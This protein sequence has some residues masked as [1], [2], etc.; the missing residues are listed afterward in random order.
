MSFAR[1]ARR[2]DPVVPASRL[3]SLLRQHTGERPLTS[4]GEVERR[5]SHPGRSQQRFL[6]LNTYLMDVL[7][8]DGEKPAVDVRDGET[9]TYTAENYDLVCLNE[10]WHREERHDLLGRWPNSAHIRHKSG[11]RGTNLRTM[12]ASAGLVTISRDFEIVA[13]HF[14]EY[15]ADSG[16]DRLAGKGCLLT[17]LTVPGAA[18]AV[19]SSLNLYNTHFQ[20]GGS[21]R[22][23]QVME[24][25]RFIARTR[26][27]VRGDLGRPGRRGLNGIVLAGDFNIDRH[28]DAQ[29]DVDRLYEEFR[30]YPAYLRDAMRHDV[31]EDGSFG[32]RT[33]R[34]SEYQFLRDIMR[35]L[36]LRDLWVWRN[37]SPGH[38]SDVHLR[39]IGEIICRPDPSNP[40]LCDDAYD[41][42]S[43]G[44]DPQ[45]TAIDYIF[46]SQTT[47]AMSFSMDFTRPRRPR[48]ARNPRAPDYLD[49]AWLSDHLG[50]STDIL[51]S[52]RP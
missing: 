44:T 22:F 51:I 50:I 23:R 48:T 2:I 38:T 39:Q 43:L 3:S 5:H 19:P 46:V 35:A 45:S 47:D 8:G 12:L 14:H 31:Q 1:I 32:E 10:V 18:S 15:I 6:I 29:V 4:L 52:P 11:G 40:G 26:D 33:A 9:G 17:V 20:A 24:L 37:G 25:A 34:K 27:Q 16:Q 49:I 28:T 30:E 42:A 41:A 13:S 36:G 7:W 21:D